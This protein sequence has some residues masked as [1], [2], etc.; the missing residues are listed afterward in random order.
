[1]SAPEESSLGQAIAAH[2]AGHYDDA[3]KRYRLVLKANPQNPDALALLGVVLTETKR[4]DEGLALLEKA[5]V[6]DPQAALFHFYKGNALLVDGIFEQAVSAYEEALRLQPQTPLFQY[7]LGNALRALNRWQEAATAYEETLRKEPQHA[8]ARNN[9]ALT[10]EHF[11]RLQEA[12]D[13]LARSVQD[14]PSY[15]EGWLNLCRVAERNGAFDLS[16]HAGQ[17]A[18][19]LAPRN[20][21][22]FLGIGVALNRLERHGEALAAYRTALDLKPDWVEVWD[23]IGQTHQ[24][25]NQLNEAATAFR[26]TMELSG[27]TLADDDVLHGDESVFGNRHWHLALLELLQGDLRLGFARYRARFSDLGVKRPS[28]AQSLWRGEELRGRTILVYDEQGMGDCLM[29]ARYLPLL[30]QRGAHVKLHVQSAL[31][32][33]LEG[34]SGVDEIIPRGKDV[35]AFDMYA[36]IFD[37]PYAFGT[38]LDSVPHDTPYLPVLKSD[39]DTLLEPTEKRKIGIVWAGAPKHKHDA[40]RSVPLAVFAS[41]F[42]LPDCQFYNLNRDLREG[43]V[44]LLAQHTNVVDL[45][46]RLRHFGDLARFVAQMD[47]IITCDTAT[48]HLAGGMGKNVWTLLPFAPDWRWLCDRVDSVWYPTMRLF[49]QARS[50]DWVG[51]LVQV[52]G[53]LKTPAVH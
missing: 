15:A 31:V 46:P 13:M 10:H 12:Q 49:R 11:G 32:P 3:E 45:V 21:S 36:S 34:W 40:R 44:S 41:L 4:T 38:T 33:L 30:K 28:Y 52:K 53:Q 14:H 50:G 6:L 18:T 20:A 26:K 29:M 25:L 47:L 1:M 9:L 42:D 22:A 16:L 48:A 23:N 2:R 35:G 17:Q 19:A 37:L 7:N 8:E 27:Q 39:V 24:F 43:D 5:L 51:V